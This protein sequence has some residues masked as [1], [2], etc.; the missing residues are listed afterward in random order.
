VTYEEYRRRVGDTA[1][2]VDR[3]VRSP[4]GRTGAAAPHIEAALRLYR[5]ALVAWNIKFESQSFEGLRDKYV[6]VGGD[7]IVKGCDSVSRYL[8]AASRA[9]EVVDTPFGAGRILTQDISVLWLCAS[10]RIAEAEAAAR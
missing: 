3:Y 8:E 7:P 9:G 1:I 2:S 5:L 10:G 6:E 4:E